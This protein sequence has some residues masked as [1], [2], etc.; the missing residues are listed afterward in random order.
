MSDGFA[1]VPAELRAGATQ[2][3]AAGQPLHTAATAI[4]PAVGVAVAMNLGYETSRALRSFGNAVRQAAGRTQ[5]RID[6]HGKALQQTAKNYEETD[7]YSE[8]E[9]RRFL[10]A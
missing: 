8:D 4:T 7:E 2:I 9:F 5:E 3:R 6:E 10:T 1:V